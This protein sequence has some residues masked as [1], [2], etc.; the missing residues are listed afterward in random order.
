M[1]T[2]KILI[3]HDFL[4]LFDLRQNRGEI[5]GIILQTWRHT[6]TYHIIC[7]HRFT[8]LGRKVTCQST[9]R[10]ERLI[11]FYRI[12]QHG[13]RHRRSQCFRK[14]ALIQ[15]GCL[16][17]QH[18]GRYTQEWDGQLTKR[19]RVGIPNSQRVKEVDD[20]ISRHK[21]LRQ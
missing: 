16:T 4:E 2:I 20:I 21:T 13:Y 5:L 18:I 15:Y 12:K 8:L 7:S 11:H 10:I 1:I 3:G 14:F 9:I 19:E 17:A 6:Y